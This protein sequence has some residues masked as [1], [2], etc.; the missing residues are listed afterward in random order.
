MRDRSWISSLTA[1]GSVAAASLCCLPIIPLTLAA[2]AAGGG[3]L[4]FSKYQPYLLALS[5]ACIVFAFWQASRARQCSLQRRTVN[6]LLIA[7]AAFFTGGA[8]LFPQAM[9]NLL[10]P[11]A[12]S[13]TSDAAF[14]LD[15][16]VPVRDQFNSA[17]SN[18]IRVVAL[19]SPT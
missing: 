6:F 17:P 2:G 10:T 5:A 12:R 8:L 15:S 16:F 4:A 1:L 13:A 14:T 18:S 3:W 7:I 9:A 19:F 11:G